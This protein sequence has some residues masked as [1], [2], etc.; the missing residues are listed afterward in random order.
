MQAIIQQSGNNK[1]TFRELAISVCAIIHVCYYI[2][3]LFPFHSYES[4]FLS[5]LI[6]ISV[7]AIL[8]KN[9][10]SKALLF[11][12]A[13][14][15]GI[16][17]IPGS[18]YRGAVSLY[19]LQLYSISVYFASVILFLFELLYKKNTTSYR[20]KVTSIFFVIY[21]MHLTL[22]Y[23]V[24]TY[25]ISKHGLIIFNQEERFGLNASLGYI[26]KS[27]I[28]VPLIL[29]IVANKPK[30]FYV[31]FYYII[32]F[33]P[34]L[35]IGSRGTVVMI[36]LAV[37]I[38]ERMKYSSENT[39]NNS[40]PKVNSNFKFIAIGV[41]AV[42]MIVG[43]FYMRRQNSTLLKSAD[44]IMN[45]YFDDPG[46][47]TYALA[48]LHFSLREQIG[49]T[50]YIISQQLRGHMGYPM[51]V[52]DFFTLLPGK[53]E[54]AGIALNYM[55]TGNSHAGLTPGLL[56]ALYL[57]YNFLAI[58]ALPILIFL[59][60]IFF[61]PFKKISGLSIVLYALTLT[62]FFHIF[63][64]GFLKPE[65]VFA[66]VVVGFYFLFLSREST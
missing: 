64:R 36:L 6:L 51:F 47:V 23:S 26:L 59:I 50:E 63:H 24:L 17:L 5:T 33:L 56:G 52:A 34:A 9:L 29:S 11:F 55:M 15:Y 45:T 46:K 37:L 44:V 8:L 54:S 28:Y 57:D 35:F 38:A 20:Y 7:N 1:G 22:I 53:Q 42:I 41:F 49:I 25:V 62:Q 40:S 48:P 18:T 31:L 14:Y 61:L 30:R 39:S 43:F 27:G 65:Y 66:Y 13:A 21:L 12:L 19:T 16:S 60:N 58:F 32:P 2:I 10:G 3:L 4:L